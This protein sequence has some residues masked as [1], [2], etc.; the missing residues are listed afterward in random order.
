MKNISFDRVRAK[1]ANREANASVASE[2][3]RINISSLVG[4]SS[5]GFTM[6]VVRKNEA[7]NIGCINP[8]TIPVA[9][10]M[11]S[12]SNIMPSIELS[13]ALIEVNSGINIQGESRAGLFLYRYLR[14]MQSP[15]KLSRIKYQ[16]M[17]NLAEASSAILF[18]HYE[19]LVNQPC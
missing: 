19:N 10:S 9:N 3:G 2:R 17:H 13:S 1:C 7:A 15:K 5:Q 16:K 4:K 8:I 14:H 18:M 6:N 12:G 11:A